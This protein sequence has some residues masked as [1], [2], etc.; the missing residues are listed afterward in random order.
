[1]T[2][3][4]APASMDVK[5]MLCKLEFTSVR[6]EA[7]LQGAVLSA[8]TSWRRGPSVGLDYHMVGWGTHGSRRNQ[9][10]LIISRWWSDN[11]VDFSRVS[12]H[13]FYELP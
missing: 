5:V 7:G 12:N 4:S 9:F 1:V 2:F 3:V 10:N 6:E 11:L 8:R 13:F